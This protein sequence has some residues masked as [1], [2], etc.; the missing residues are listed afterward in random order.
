VSSVVAVLRYPVKSA[1]GERLRS[2]AVDRDGLRWDR[3]WACLDLADGTVGSAKHPRRWGRL[4]EVTA[5]VDERAEAGAVT[6]SL[7]ERRFR[8]GSAAADAAVSG[9]LGRP[10][11]LTSV[12]PERAMLHRQLPDDDGLVPEWMTDAATGQETITE[13]SGALPGGRFVDFGAVHLVTTGALAGLARQLGRADVDASRFR[14]NLVLD[15]PQDPEPEQKLQIGDVVL[16]VV[17]PTP[18]CVVP[19][20][21]PDAG[22]AIDRQLLST[23]AREHRTAV[24]DLGRAACFGVYAEVLHPGQIEVGQ[25]VR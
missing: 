14:P 20:L 17:L 18:R 3:A 4:L 13:V 1:R 8:A 15:A 5:R 24:A 19:G 10:V 7:A 2:V 9:H 21:D 25:P 23:L 22:V 16:R 11:R 6:V 12:V